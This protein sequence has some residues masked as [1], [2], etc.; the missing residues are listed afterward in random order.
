MER[1]LNR[2][3][4][5]RAIRAFG[6]LAA[7]LAGGVVLAQEAA[8]RDRVAQLVGRLDADKQD[9]REAAEKALIELGPRVLPVLPDPASVKSAEQKAGLQRVREALVAAQEK[10]SFTASIVTIQGEGIR[11]SEAL[12][13]L[14]QQSGNLITDLRE[15]MGQEAT[16]PAIDLDIGKKPFFEALDVICKAAEVT[17]NFYTGD[18]SIGL[19]GGAPGLPVQIGGGLTRLASP[20]VYTGPFRVQFRQIVAS[21][22][23]VSGAATAN[24]QFE[25]A[26]EPRL[27]PMLLALRSED[28]EILDDRGTTVLPSVSEESASV[29]LRPENPAAEMNLNM[30]APDRQAQRLATLKVKALMTLPAG[31]RS[32]R[33][34]DLTKPGK[35]SQGDVSVSL[36]SMSVEEHVW[37]LR[38]TLNYPGEGPAFESYRQGLFNNQLWLQGRD[39]GRLD[40]NGPHGG[41]FSNLGSDGGRLV[42]EYLFVDVPGKPADYGLVYE[43]P[44]R[45][46]TIPIEFEF[47]DVPL[48]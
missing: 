46:E 1:R 47:K 3:P 14:Q 4:G 6:L 2:R 18:G 28:V 21:K 44:S 27:R 38:V 12:K 13:Q 20:V 24:A 42:F 5:L 33:F 22:D 16:N 26:W 11:L 15:Q 48:P 43:T 40:H 39:G 37:K 35:Q 8:L 31:V 29:V 34:A 32:F 36:D 10:E 17:P 9:V 41:G 23:V 19:L 30:D 45:V 25:I 7:L